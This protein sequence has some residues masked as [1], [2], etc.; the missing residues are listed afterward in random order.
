LQWNRP[1]IP[2]NTPPIT[3]PHWIFSRDEVEMLYSEGEKPEEQLKIRDKREKGIQFIHSVG[4]RL[5][6]H[7]IILLWHYYNAT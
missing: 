4:H 3:P 5:G 6:L 2:P 7:V 1:T